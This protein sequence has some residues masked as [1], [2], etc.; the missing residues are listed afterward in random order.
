MTRRR[1]DRRRFSLDRERDLGSHCPVF[2]DSA[3]PPA[4][5]AIRFVD[6]PAREYRFSCRGGHSIQGPTVP[7]HAH[8][9]TVAAFARVHRVCERST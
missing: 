4:H 8:V 5:I 1:P 7:T 9:A 6:G 2:F 3:D